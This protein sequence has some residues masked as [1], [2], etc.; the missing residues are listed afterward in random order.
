MP[1][2]SAYLETLAAATLL[3]A[4]AAK[5]GDR[6]FAGIVAQHVRLPERCTRVLAGSLPYA[7]ILTGV[8]L[9]L[10][11]ARPIP[12]VAAS[13]FF[14]LFA[15]LMARSLAMGGAER[16]CGCY[17]S[18]RPSPPHWP[19]ALSNLGLGVAAS[20]GLFARAEP[21]QF[22]DRLSIALMAVITIGVS[23]L[24]STTINVWKLALYER[25]GRSHAEF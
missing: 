9:L 3:L 10:G 11:V 1:W 21:L 17:G 7:E 16:S 5:L 20:S 4:G 25:L 19:K 6:G 24:L 2:I 22:E 13:A 8:A 14:F 23:W 18:S 12:H 15:L